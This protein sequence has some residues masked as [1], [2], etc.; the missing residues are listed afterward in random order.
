MHRHKEWMSIYK[1]VLQCQGFP[2]LIQLLTCNVLKINY[3]ISRLCFVKA[4]FFHLKLKKKIKE[5]Q[6]A[7]AFKQTIWYYLLIWGRDSIQL[8]IILQYDLCP[9]RKSV[10]RLSVVSR[11]T[12][13]ILIF[14]RL[15]SQNKNYLPDRLVNFSRKYMA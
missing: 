6:F 5:I 15:L 4:D 12:K 13:M 8:K 1:I 14:R 11:H 3:Y 10:L 9:S 7:Y 2:L